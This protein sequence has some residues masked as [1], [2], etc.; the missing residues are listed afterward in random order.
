M[1]VHVWVS[2]HTYIFQLC[3]LRGPR[4]NASPEAMNTPS[5]KILASK[6]YSPKNNHPGFHVEVVDSRVRGGKIQDEPETSCGNRK[7]GSAQKSTE[8]F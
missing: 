8:A 4:N 2:I 7:K 3:L 5:P 6:Y 1:C